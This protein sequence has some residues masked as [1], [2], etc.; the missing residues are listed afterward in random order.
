MTNLQTECPEQSSVRADPTWLG[1]RMSCRVADDFFFN[2]K[3]QPQW[4]APSPY[5]KEVQRERTTWVPTL[6][7]LFL[8][9]SVPLAVSLCNIQV[10]LAPDLMNPGSMGV[11][12]REERNLNFPLK[13]YYSLL[14][15]KYQY[16]C[17]TLV[18]WETLLRS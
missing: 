15:C 11:G 13:T 6:N 5:P 3:C 2:S 14:Q 16:H 18:L 4:G 9:I 7:E 10:L 12:K 1:M 17:K 8:S